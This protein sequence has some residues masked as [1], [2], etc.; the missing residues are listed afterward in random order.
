M[1]LQPLFRNFSE[2]AYQLIL[3]S[4]VVIIYILVC[5][6]ADIYVPAFPQM[7]KYFDVAENEIQLIL[8]INFI[9]LFFSGLI[10]GPLSDSF[11]RRK[12]I[13]AGLALLMVSS[14][15]LVMLDNFKLLLFWRFIQGI[16]AAVPMVCGGAMLFDKYSGEKASKLIGFLNAVITA[17]MAAA[18]V[19]GAYISEVFGWRANFIAVMLLSIIAFIGFL[20][21]LEESLDSKQERQ[22]NLRSIIKD[23]GVVL[24]NSTFI[25]YCL[26]SCFP[27]ITI[28]VY[29]TNLSVIFIN[30]LGISLTNY[31]YYQATT[32]GS[33]VIFSLYSVKLIANKGVEYTKNLGAI[34]SIIGVVGLFSTSIIAHTSAIFI[35]VS[36]AIL[37]AGGSMVAG[38]FGM[39]ALSLF[40]QMNGTAL[41]ACT[42]IRLFLISAFVLLSEIYFDG[43]ITPIAYI[44]TG[45]AIFTASFYAWLLAKDSK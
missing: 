19:I 24:K 8:S 22:F 41:A 29:I 15:I 37:A 10:A 2:K 44:I 43:T 4:M 38:T 42:A 18:P 11:G 36:M 33:F 25:C 9:G 21:F 45:Y 3:L 23:Y 12:V 26:I 14:I 6:E 16:A 32:M 35:C 1:I 20:L 34:I 5:A 13:L 17:A 31:G 28:I 39:K 7:I 27:F 40:P 30:H